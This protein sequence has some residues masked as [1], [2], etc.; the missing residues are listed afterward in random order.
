M[1][2]LINDKNLQKELV[3]K[4]LDKVRNFTW[5]KSAL[6]HIKIFKEL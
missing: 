4:G 1:E 5:R 6:E 2:I 3:S